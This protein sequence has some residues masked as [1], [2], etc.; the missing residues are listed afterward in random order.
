M[1]ITKMNLE[2]IVQ[3][4]NEVKEEEVMEDVINVKEVVP[5]FQGSQS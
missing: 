4:L 2:K 3:R 5:Q 1:D